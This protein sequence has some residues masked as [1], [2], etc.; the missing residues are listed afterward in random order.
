ML[1]LSFSL[2]RPNPIM[3]KDLLGIPG[4]RIGKER[5]LARKRQG[6]TSS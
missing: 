5:F 2:A 6:R 4:R 3:G 1:I